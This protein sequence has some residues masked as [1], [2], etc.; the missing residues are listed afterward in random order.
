MFWTNH[1]GLAYLNWVINEQK[2][3]K[4]LKKVADCSVTITE[5]TQQH[6]TQGG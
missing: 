1:T 2:T 6:M 3:G 4:K 5:N